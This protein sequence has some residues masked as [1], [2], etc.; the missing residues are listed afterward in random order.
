MWTLPNIRE[1][2]T[3]E[4]VATTPKIPCPKI[5]LKVEEPV[6]LIPIFQREDHPIRLIMKNHHWP[7]D[8]E[9]RRIVPPSPLPSSS[10]DPCNIEETT[11]EVTKGPRDVCPIDCSGPNNPVI[12]A[13]LE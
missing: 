6:M 12:E 10:T 8:Q 2:A 9:H 1:G 13:Q 3:E 7:H 11:Q 4:E 5:L